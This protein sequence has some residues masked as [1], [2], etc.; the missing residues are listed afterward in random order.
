MKTQPIAV[1]LVSLLLAGGAAQA[2]DQV[3][4]RGRALHVL[5]PDQAAALQG[6]YAMADGRTLEVT[7]SA[8]RVSVVFD[9][10]ELPML[11]ISPTRLQSADGAL[12]L[13]FDAATNGSVRGL[14]LSVSTAQAS[15]PSAPVLAALAAASRAP[16]R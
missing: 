3:E 7:R 12:T 14:T 6:R 1:A 9:G 5:T 8:R 10:H 4:V 13:T 15:G 11:A 16:G 2:A